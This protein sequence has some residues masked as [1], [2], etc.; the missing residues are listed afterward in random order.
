MSRPD[1]IPPGPLAAPRGRRARDAISLFPPPAVVRHGRFRR[2]AR[3]PTA[4]SSRRSRSRFASPPRRSP[5]RASRGRSASSRSIA[6]A[7][8]PTTR[9]SAPRARSSPSWSAPSSRVPISCGRW[10]PTR[11]N[12]GPAETTYLT[13]GGAATTG[14][15]DRHPLPGR[16][17]LARGG[18]RRR[19]CGARRARQLTLRRGEGERVVPRDSILTFADLMEQAEAAGDQPRRIPSGQRT[20]RRLV[21]DVLP[22]DH[23]ARSRAHHRAPGA[24]P[25]ERGSGEVLRARGRAHHHGRPAGHRGRAGQARAPCSASSPTGQRSPAAARRRGRAPVQCA[26]AG[27]VLAPDLLLSPARP[28]TELREMVFFGTLFALVCC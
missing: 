14:P 9:H 26:G 27:G 16:D 5:A 1:P 20:L 3:S 17:A 18:R 19:A 23:R 8:P 6:S 11:A 4:P 13:D 12:L 21:G 25:R 15:G 2:S 22:A 24:A 28:T 10:R 7:P